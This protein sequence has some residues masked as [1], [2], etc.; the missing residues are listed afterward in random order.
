MQF[1]LVLLCQVYE[2]G[3]LLITSV[4]Y[5]GK[6]WDLGVGFPDKTL[7]VEFFRNKVTPFLPRALILLKHSSNVEAASELLD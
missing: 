7:L 2:R 4:F 1:S 5:R 6:G 3:D